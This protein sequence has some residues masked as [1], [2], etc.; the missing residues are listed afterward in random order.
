M[1]VAVEG[2]EDDIDTR[3]LGPMLEKAQ[4]ILEAETLT[5]LGDS[6]YYSSKQI[7]TCEDKN[8]SVYVP[9]S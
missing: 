4:D 3:Q 7:K 5:G 6:D 1:R 2:T 9:I 8:I